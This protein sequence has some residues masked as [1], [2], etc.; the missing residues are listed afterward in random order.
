MHMQ[1]PPSRPTLDTIMA[2]IIVLGILGQLI[3]AKIF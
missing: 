1:D 2:I 3:A